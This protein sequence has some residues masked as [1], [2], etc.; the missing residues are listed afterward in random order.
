MVDQL[1]GRLSNLEYQDH[2]TLMQIGTDVRLYIRRIFGQ[3]SVWMHDMEQIRF[4]PK[5][6]IADSQNIEMTGAWKNGHKLLDHMLHAMRKE[7]LAFGVPAMITEEITV[8][9]LLKRL[10]PKLWLAFASLLLA[11]FGAGVTLG[12]T[13]FIRELFHK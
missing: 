10:P 4:S 3:D 1:I 7:L 6:F 8:D 13:T 9:W 2:E 5:G 11:V 12:Q